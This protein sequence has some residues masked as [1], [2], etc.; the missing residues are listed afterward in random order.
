MELETNYHS[1]AIEGTHESG[2]EL[3]DIYKDA[4]AIEQNP[5]RLFASPGEVQCLHVPSNA[6]LFNSHLLH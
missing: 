2:G 5:M 1:P 4:P 3:Y 6:R